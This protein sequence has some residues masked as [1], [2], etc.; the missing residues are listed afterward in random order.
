M[1][2]LAVLFELCPVDEGWLGVGFVIG[3]DDVDADDVGAD[4][5]AVEWRGGQPG[6]KRRRAISFK[7]M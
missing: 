3:V 5:W 4:D 1:E 7:L 6:G 2:K